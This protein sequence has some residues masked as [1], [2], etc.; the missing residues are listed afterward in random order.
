[1]SQTQCEIIRD[2][3][4]LYIDSVC[5]K[6]SR[7]LVDTHMDE[8]EECKREYQLLKTNLIISEE[9]DAAAIRKIK[10][11]IL[12]E[13]IIIV[14][15]IIFVMAF[16]ALPVFFEFNTGYKSMNDLLTADMVSVEEDDAGNL[17]LIRKD[18]A[19]EAD[20]AAAN[21]YTL[22]GEVITD[23][24]GLTLNTDIDKSQIVIRIELCTTPFNH[25]KLKTIGC[26]SMIKEEQSVLINAHDKTN[27]N[28]IIIFTPDAPKGTVLWTQ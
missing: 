10:R 26:S 28:Q 14:L 20:Y 22:D 24:L 9:N 2:L 15:L 13:K 1:M 4:P 5:S 11:R 16:I 27:I 23:F 17:W 3:L 8:C 7:L 12:T 19:T 25:F 6:E 21:Q 18:A